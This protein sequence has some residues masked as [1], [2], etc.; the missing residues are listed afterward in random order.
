[1]TLNRHL[2]SWAA[3]IPNSI[4]PGFP[5]LSYPSEDFTGG[6]FYPCPT[7]SAGDQCRSVRGIPAKLVLFL[8]AIQQIPDLGVRLDAQCRFEVA[9]GVRHSPRDAGQRNPQVDVGLGGIRIGS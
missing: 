2:P 6:K 5:L 1:M 9:D 4:H 8:Q 7:A 3:E